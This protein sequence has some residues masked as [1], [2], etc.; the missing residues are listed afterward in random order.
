MPAQLGGDPLPMNRLLAGVMQNMDLPEG[1]ED[2]AAFGFHR[3]VTATDIAYRLLP[4]GCHSPIRKRW[5]SRNERK[6]QLLAESGRVPRP[7]TQYGF[8]TGRARAGGN[9]RK[10]LAR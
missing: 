7:Q 1:E 2:F 3:I 4:S 9:R 6:I 8:V 5:S 10:A